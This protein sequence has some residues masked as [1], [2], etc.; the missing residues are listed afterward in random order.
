[1]RSGN[2][3]PT[4][5]STWGF[6]RRRQLSLRSAGLYHEPLLVLLPAAHPLAHKQ[7]LRVADLAAERLLLTEPGCAYRRLTKQGLV[8]QSCS[9]QP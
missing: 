4:A 3:S 8:A 5:T 6:V 2:G 1:M 9:R 7:T